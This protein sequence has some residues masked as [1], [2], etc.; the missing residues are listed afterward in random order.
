MFLF[1]ILF[2][3]IVTSPHSVYNGL[4]HSYIDCSDLVWSVLKYGGLFLPLGKNVFLPST[5]GNFR[6][7]I[8]KS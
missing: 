7:E 3:F 1:Y 8:S 2:Y 5:G 6:L 4:I